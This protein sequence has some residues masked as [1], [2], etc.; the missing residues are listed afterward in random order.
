MIILCYKLIYILIIY[1]VLYYCY[2]RGKGEGKR[3]IG[4]IFRLEVE[5]EYFLRRSIFFGCFY[6]LLFIWIECEES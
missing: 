1:Y 6:F 4:V 3:M 2:R 5:L